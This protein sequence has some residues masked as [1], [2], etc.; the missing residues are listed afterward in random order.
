MKNKNTIIK[1]IAILETE[2]AKLISLQRDFNEICN[3]KKKDCY[4]YCEKYFL[5]AKLSLEK[6]PSIIKPI[7]YKFTPILSMSEGTLC[8]DGKSVPSALFDYTN[9][10]E[11]F[12]KAQNLFITNANTLLTSLSE[13]Q[14]SEQTKNLLYHLSYNYNTIFDFYKSRDDLFQ[15]KW[16][17]EY[18]R[19]CSD[20]NSAIKRNSEISGQIDKL[21]N[22]LRVYDDKQHKLKDSV[23]F[24][25]DSSM[26]ES[27]AD[28]IHI[29]IAYQEE[30]GNISS[31]LQWELEK[32]S[33]LCIKT[34]RNAEKSDGIF[35]IISNTV[36]RFINSFP[37]G[38]TRILICDLCGDSELRNLPVQLV[39]TDEKVASKLIY[40][41]SEKKQMFLTDFDDT[42]KMASG[43]ITE[44]TALYRNIYDFNAKN[45]DSFSYPLLIIINGFTKEER[46]AKSIIDNF[47]NGTQTGVY[48]LVTQFDDVCRNG[49]AYE[50]RNGF[51]NVRNAKIL[52]ASIDNEIIRV[53]YKGSALTPV[54]LTK[55]F[56][57]N[58]YST[59]L[60]NRISSQKNDINLQEVIKGYTRDGTDFSEEL[61]IPVGRLDNASTKVFSLSSRN[62]SAHCVVAGATGTGKSSLLQAIVLGGAYH[63]SPDELEFYLIDMKDGASFY[64]EEGY[65]YSKLKH[66]RMMAANC[67]PKDLRDFIS[68][69][70]ETKT[71]C[72]EATDIVVYN[73]S[74][75]GSKKM[76]RTIIIIDEYTIIDDDKCIADL[77]TIAAQGRSFGVSL[78]L[79]SQNTKG[80][81]SRVLEKISTSVEFENVKLGELIE[82]D[83]KCRISKNEAIYLS[84]LKGN[85]VGRSGMSLSKFR[86]A[87]TPDQNG[88]IEQINEKYSSYPSAPTIII[89]ND[90]RQIYSFNQ[91]EFVGSSSCEDSISVNIGKNLFGADIRYTMSK[92][93]GKLLLLGDAARAQSIEYSLMLA[94]KNTISTNDKTV[95]HLNFGENIITEDM[96]NVCK[97]FTEVSIQPL[98]LLYSVRSIYKI[99]EE[100]RKAQKDRRRIARS[101]DKQYAPPVLVVLHDCAQYKSW[102]DSGEE[103]EKEK[104]NKNGEIE[105][106]HTER[107]PEASIKTPDLNFDLD[108]SQLMQAIPSRDLF[109]TF[110]SNTENVDLDASKLLSEVIKNGATYNIYFVVHIDSSVVGKKVHNLFG[111]ALSML[112]EE[113]IIIPEVSGEPA[114]EK[115]QI[116]SALDLLNKAKIKDNI[117]KSGEMTERE[118][119]R[120]YYVMGDDYT[121]II[122]YEW[123]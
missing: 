54:T 78:I 37:A 23:T 17:D 10:F 38:T 76:K 92:K 5:E 65:D 32:E 52:S 119:C 4:D 28:E 60:Q 98:D 13:L 30:N 64:K 22:E 81:F 63:Y 20:K 46:I 90:T 39:G 84:E 9:C 16:N 29:P 112:F 72:N 69:I 45:P 40:G 49:Y 99:Y 89:G 100:R 82:R 35:D 34:S 110:K 44:R 87:Y 79:T 33:V 59:I 80:A 18:K 75:T 27:F 123:R 95:F 114:R 11:V 12:E 25:H 2:Q 6:M 36:C 19:L 103:E 15:S 104:H 42:I 67:K 118:L 58:Q 70:K 106:D 43:L 53:S 55:N 7:V 61:K 117:E 111:E 74:R 88:L 107:V 121:Q 102:L 86:V 91:S 94:M 101:G 113:A 50:D 51:D 3:Q 96:E 93:S 83:G 48:F 68:F 109:A 122:P 115:M 14:V 57:I 1:D 56:D 26:A 73:K 66:V 62:S 41:Y 21:K 85:C 71:H 120:C 8:L 77:E 108:F 47:T 24:T 105:R 97:D 116:L 31:F